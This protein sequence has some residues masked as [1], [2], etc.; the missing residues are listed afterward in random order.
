MSDAMSIDR[1]AVISVSLR[2]FVEFLIKMTE[3]GIF[4]LIYR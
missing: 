2:S 1:G 3:R 4:A